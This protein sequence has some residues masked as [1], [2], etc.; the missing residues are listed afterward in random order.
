[1]LKIS[2]KLKVNEF[3]DSANTKSWITKVLSSL[4]SNDDANSIVRGGVRMSDSTTTNRRVHVRNAARY[5]QARTQELALWCSHDRA[6]MRA[7]HQ[8]VPVNTH[9]TPLLPSGRRAMGVSQTKHHS[10]PPAQHR[11]PT[12]I[13][14]GM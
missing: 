14:R 9:S 4:R 5:P 11:S 13:S 3:D 8:W 2:Y 12:Y 6:W 10:T 1:M 7:P